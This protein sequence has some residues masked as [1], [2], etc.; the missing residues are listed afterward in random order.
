MQVLEILNLQ[1]QD[2]LLKA[3]FLTLYNFLSPEII[4]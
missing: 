2:P 4:K 3:P 1:I